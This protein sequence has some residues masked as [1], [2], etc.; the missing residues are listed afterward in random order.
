MRRLFL[1]GAT[2][3]LGREV[4]RQA[5][6]TG[7]TV[8][9]PRRVDVRDRAAVREAVAAAAPDAVV[10]TAY[11]QDGP[12][13]E[14]VNVGGSAHVAQAAVQ[15]G[16]RL[17]HLSSDVIFRGGLGRP[18]V[19]SD[20]PDPVTAYGATKAAAEAAV[21]AADPGAV[22]VRT[23]LIYGGREPSKHEQRALAA[24]DGSAD[25]AFYEDEWRSPV[26][27]ADLAAAVLELATLPEVAGP[28]NVAGADPVSRLEFARLVA[29]RHG[30]DPERLRGA[31]RPP[32]RPGD[33][34]L[35]CRVAQALLTTRLRGVREVLAV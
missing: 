15:A 20:P 14:E 8:L 22:L 6:A 30:R 12:E 35:D 27:V 29:A 9:P 24:A 10:H 25:G 33:C 28:L 32:G 34:A 4:A 21:A 2:G 19:E 7:W 11:V 1:T 18:L 26:A 13:A 23:S 31:P 5:Q 17:V 3:Y 16:A